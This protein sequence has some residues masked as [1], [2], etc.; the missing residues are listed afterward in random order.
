M[1]FS[2]PPTS[3]ADVWLLLDNIQVSAFTGGDWI[4]ATVGPWVGNSSISSSTPGNIAFSFQ[5]TAISFK[6]NTPSSRFSP[7]WFLASIDSNTPYNVSFPDAG[8]TQIYTQWYQTP[9]LIDGLHTINL[10]RIAVGFDYAII[11][12]GPTTPL[13][14]STIVVDDR[15]SEV[16]YNGNGWVIDVNEL[17]FGEDMIG[18]LPM[19]N[20][21]HRTSS[22]GD[23]FEFQ[24]AGDSIALYGFFEWT[25][26]GS[27]SI[28]FTLDNETTP[29]SLFLHGGAPI[30]QFI[31][32]YQFF[33]ADNIDAGN[34]TLLMN[35]TAAFGNQSFVF[36][37]LTYTPSFSLLESKPNFTSPSSISLTRHKNGAIAGGIV[38]G[39]VGLT[40]FVALTL[41]YRRGRKLARLIYSTSRLSIQ[42]LVVH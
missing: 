19:G 1:S 24:F 37:Y 9:I 16:T 34:H 32:S 18:G 29:S 33:S 36:D 28:D 35:V 4:T 22:V 41:V 3:Q 42:R 31:T 14:G 40:I 15:N 27:I 39:L 8:P 2:A 30:S 11:T 13:S 21:T 12:P 23:G 26:T 5:G 17:D 7:T 25:S 20:T 38:G 10:S 6:G